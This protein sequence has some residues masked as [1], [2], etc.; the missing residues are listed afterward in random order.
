MCLSEMRLKSV[1][2]LPKLL[3]LRK[4]LVALG[5]LAQFD[6]IVRISFRLS[7]FPWCSHLVLLPPYR[8]CRVVCCSPWRCF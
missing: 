3:D 2:K 8:V 7:S 1:I 5:N 4:S 6:S